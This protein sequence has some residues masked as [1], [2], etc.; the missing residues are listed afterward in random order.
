MNLAAV[1]GGPFG[2]IALMAISFHSRTI[3]SLVTGPDF[4]RARAGAAYMGNKAAVAIEIVART[5]ISRLVFLNVVVIVWSPR[6]DSC[7]VVSRS[8][9]DGARGIIIRE[10]IAG[11]ETQ[12]ITLVIPSGPGSKFALMSPV[13]NERKAK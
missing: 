1:N 12:P 4:E 9:M 13:K 2:R 3:A 11:P 5:Q 7:I 8:R 6:I 10:L